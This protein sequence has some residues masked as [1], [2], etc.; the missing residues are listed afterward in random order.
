MG[1][2]GFFRGV[3]RLRGSGRRV[4]AVM[5]VLAVVPASKLK[6]IADA[7]GGGVDIYTNTALSLH[8]YRYKNNSNASVVIGGLLAYF[9]RDIVIITYGGQSVW[10]IH[11]VCGAVLKLACW[12]FVCRNVYRI[13]WPA[14]PLLG[15]LSLVLGLCLLASSW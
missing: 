11:V 6:V 3:K 7:V 10:Y 13:L 5:W 15:L 2:R 12:A 1:S 9:R 8:D 14:E 4:E